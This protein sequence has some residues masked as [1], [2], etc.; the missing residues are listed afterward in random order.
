[1]ADG[2]PDTAVEGALTVKDLI[3]DDVMSDVDWSVTC[4]FCT[5]FPASAGTPCF[6][7]LRS[8]I[9]HMPS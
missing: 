2:S 7:N 6:K 8:Q 1:M 4:F 9:A 3:F 5:V